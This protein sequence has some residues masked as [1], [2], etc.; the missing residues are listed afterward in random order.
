METY[1]RKETFRICKVLNVPIRENI[2]KDAPLKIMQNNNFFALNAVFAVGK[3]TDIVGD[4]TDSARYY[5]RPRIWLSPICFNVAAK[6]TDTSKSIY[7][8]AM[9]G[10]IHEFTHYIQAS[11]TPQWLYFYPQR[12]D[13]INMNKYVSQIVEFESHAVEAYYYLE[14]INRKK[15]KEIMHSNDGMDGKFKLL[16]NEYF[17]ETKPW[18][19]FKVF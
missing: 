7:F 19:K 10:I 18:R 11:V 5:L 15:L 13:S 4:E 6:I 8:Q 14:N 17:L 16:I 3:S 2:T 12:M 1:I 9:G